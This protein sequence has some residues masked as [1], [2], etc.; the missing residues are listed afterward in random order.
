MEHEESLRDFLIHSASEF[1]VTLSGQQA[2]QFLVYLDELRQWNRVTNLTSINDPQEIVIK[3][4]I[5]SL[6]S[7]ATLDFPPQSVVID[8]GTGPG[9]PGIPLKIARN[10]IQL[11][12]I[13]PAQKKCSFLH[14]I[15]GTLKLRDTS[16]F[17]GTL[18]QYV[19]QNE[20]VRGDVIVLR[21]LRFDEIEMSLLKALKNTGKLALYRTETAVSKI[22]SRLFGIQL[23]KSFSLP[24]D[25]GHR[26]IT[27]LSPIGQ[28]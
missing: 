24:M 13:E 2:R 21:A 11:V 20:F 25:Q 5:D 6:T 17:V 18:Q 4:F 15:I 10:D 26:V 28:T 14:S 8:V 12:L 23:E 19:A 3:H 1:G 27:V 9:F 22:E 16:V 7:L